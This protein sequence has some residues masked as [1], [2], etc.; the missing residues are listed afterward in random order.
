M[1]LECWLPFLWKSRRNRLETLA[2]VSLWKMFFQYIKQWLFFSNVAVFLISNSGGKHHQETI[3]QAI[4]IYFITG[5]KNIQKDKEMGCNDLCP[6]MKN[7]LLL[8]CFLHNGLQITGGRDAVSFPLLLLHAAEFLN[9]YPAL[10]L[11]IYKS[12]AFSI[13]CSEGAYFFLFHKEDFCSHY[14]RR[15]KDYGRKLSY[16]YHFLIKIYI[17]PW[18]L[19]LFYFPLIWGWS[20]LA[21]S[22]P[23]SQRPEK[24][25]ENG[26]EKRKDPAN[27]WHL[28]YPRSDVNECEIF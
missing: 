28:W 10:S 8:H 27:Q 25:R 18:A 23:W 13:H 5:Y 19:Y 3:V 9:R 12:N 6:N 7:F 15:K 17:R 20:W 1:T 11:L 21:S 26:K 16:H 4:L 22:A 14:R 2:Q 24:I